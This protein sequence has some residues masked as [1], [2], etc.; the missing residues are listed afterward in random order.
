MI[1][2]M[3]YFLKMEDLDPIYNMRE[4]WGKFRRKIKKEKKNKKTKP[5]VNEFLKNVS[6][7]KGLL[8]EN[9]DIDKAKFL[10]SLPK[11]KLIR[12]IKKK[13]LL[14]TGRFGPC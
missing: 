12:K 9:I 2:E 13:S 7:P 3:I 1:M 6:I 8:L 4:F 11:S 5:D 10:C 14:N